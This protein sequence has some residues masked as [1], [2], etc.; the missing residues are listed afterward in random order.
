[1]I[2]TPWLGDTCSLVDA[3]RRGERSPAEELQATYDAIDASDLNAITYAPREEAMQA[4]RNADV[5][6]PFGGV[7][8]GV[9]EL[10]DVL[11]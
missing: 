1:M 8:V 11:G 7:A 3:F 5:L 6:L 4:A 10:D 9:K 2:D